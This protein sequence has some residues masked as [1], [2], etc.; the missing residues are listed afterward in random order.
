MY[1]NQYNM[2][3]PNVFND[4]Y[5]IR[6]AAKKFK[7]LFDVGRRNA[8]SIFF[9]SL[10]TSKK[11]GSWTKRRREMWPSS[12]CAFKSIYSFF[13]LR[14]CFSTF[15]FSAFYETKTIFYIETKTIV[16]I[17]ATNLQFLSI[18]VLNIMWHPDLCVINKNI[19]TERVLVQSIWS[20]F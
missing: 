5:Q 15:Y 9:F 2:K 18:P 12:S 16:I 17:L 6:N 19:D 7:Y 20:V 3:F 10:S 4:F 1:F 8:I 14:F 11:C 13:I